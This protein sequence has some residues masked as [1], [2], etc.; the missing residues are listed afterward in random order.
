[1]CLLVFAWEPEAEH[2]LVV[3]ANRDERLDRPACSLDVLRDTAPRILGG[4]DHMAG[5]TWLATNENGV[6]AGLTNRPAPGGRDATKRSRG[7]LPLIVATAG[8][9][10]DG[11]AAL[12]DIVEPGQYNPA[13]L[14]AGDRQSLFYIEL[15]TD[16][17]PVA[18]SLAPGLHVLENVGLDQPSLKVDRVRSRLAA[19]QSAGRPLP[20]A[21]GEVLADHTLPAGA[22]HE[23]MAAG[24]V[25]RRAATLACCV[26]TDDYGTRSAA[27]VRVPRAVDALPEMLV[28]DGPPCT[29]PF[30]EATSLWTS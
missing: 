22:D 25:V 21:L 14:L 4:R 29:T 23:S 30:R 26:H 5:G 20:A 24:D 16:R 11:V 6:V 15:A 2:P 7:E 27:M 8:H 28:A 10:A 12:C 3:A 18:H 1:M 19:A 13:W 9:A 17:A